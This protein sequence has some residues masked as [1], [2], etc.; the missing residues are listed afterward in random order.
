MSEVGVRLLNSW[1]H[2]CHALLAVRMDIEPNLV[3]LSRDVDCHLSL[4]VNSTM[5]IIAAHKSHLSLGV[6]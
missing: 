6:N 3:R 1:I 4:D 5:T 2:P